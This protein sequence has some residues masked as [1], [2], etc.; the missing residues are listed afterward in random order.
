MWRW[1]RSPRLETGSAGGAVD[2]DVGAGLHPPFPDN[3][4]RRL[5]HCGRCAVSY[6][7]PSPRVPGQNG[8]FGL[9]TCRPGYGAG[10]GF[11]PA[12][13]AYPEP[14]GWLR[15][16]RSVT[17]GSF[18]SS[19]SI[20]MAC[21]SSRLF[22]PMADPGTRVRGD[23]GRSGP[24]HGRRGGPRSTGSA[25][26]RAAPLDGGWPGSRPP[27]GFREARTGNSYVEAGLGGRCR[28]LPSSAA[29]GFPWLVTVRA[30]GG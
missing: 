7:G 27:P 22:R 12:G 24:V 11:F 28:S 14:N 15:S 6:A 19:S 10:P 13:R 8:A 30:A 2:V 21:P 29:A 26:S 20:L 17:S 5:A 1:T 23:R 18:W 25:T 3:P 4:S 16:P 9:R